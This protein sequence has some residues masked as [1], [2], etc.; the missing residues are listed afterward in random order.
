LLRGARYEGTKRGG[1]PECEHVPFHAAIR[2]Q[3]PRARIV[4][5]PYLISGP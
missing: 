4:V 2:A 3:F 5:A 1:A